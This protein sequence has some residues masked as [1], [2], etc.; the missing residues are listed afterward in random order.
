MISLLDYEC[1]DKKNWITSEELMDVT[2]IAES[3]PGP[4]AINCATYTG[5]KQ[6]GIPGAVSATLGIILPSFL[7][8]LFFST[9]LEQI[10]NH[11]SVVNA[12]KGIRIAVSILI[13]QSGI[14]MSGKMMK[15]TPYKIID[16]SF[17]IA[18]FSILLALN[19]LNVRF[20][21]FYLVM[22]AGLM[23]FFIHALLRRGKSDK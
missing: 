4:I 13:I 22:I 5:Y 10:I 2:A 18:S 14:K 19:L 21:T 9:F 7:I 16:L 11:P 20:S 17:T 3:T 12:F 15:K 8:I 23:G 6:G 1:V